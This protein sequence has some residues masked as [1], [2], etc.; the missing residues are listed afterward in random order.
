MRENH[1]LMTI[2]FAAAFLLLFAFA[3][4]F[5]HRALKSFRGQKR[6]G[7]EPLLYVQ[8]RYDKIRRVTRVPCGVL[9]ILASDDSLD[10]NGKRQAYARLRE[11]VLA[12]FGE[13]DDAVACE[14]N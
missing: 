13:T 6:A 7:F 14:L 8:R 2:I 11:T 3:L 9:Y 10:E 12:S 5:V 4:V 1:I